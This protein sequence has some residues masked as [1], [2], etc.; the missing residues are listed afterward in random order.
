MIE[1]KRK[2]SRSIKEI[3]ATILEQLNRGEIESANL[4]EFLGVDRKI[5]LEN[6]LMQCGRKNT[7]NRF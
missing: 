4:V 1:I 2:G 5:L 3:P 7:W 6:L